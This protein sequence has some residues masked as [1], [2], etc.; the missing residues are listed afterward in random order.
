[1]VGGVFTP[2]LHGDHGRL[3]AR[4]DALSC[5]RAVR[6]RASP[7]TVRA[8]CAHAGHSRRRGHRWPGGRRGAA[9]SR[10]PGHG[11]GAQPGPH[12]GRRRDLTCSPTGS[13]R[14]GC[15][16]WPTRCARSRHRTTR[17]CG[18]VS[19]SRPAGGWSRSPRAPRRTSP[20][21]TARTSSACC[22]SALPAGGVRTGVAVTGVEHARGVVTDA[23]GARTSADLVIG[24]DGLRS[25]VRGTFARGALAPVRRLHRVARSH[26]WPR[27]TSS[28]PP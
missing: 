20:S 12:G 25:A 16:G 7:C 21:C 11:A 17:P 15:W 10:S 18:P 3:I 4:L 1:M 5:A 23:S 26:R 14:C 8:S 27:W 22:S 28:A 13:P 2:V 6:E 19:G 24:A 9:P